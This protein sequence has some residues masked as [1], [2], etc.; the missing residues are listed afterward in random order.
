MVALWTVSVPRPPEFRE[1]VLFGCDQVAQRDDVLVGPDG[2]HPSTGSVDESRAQ[3]L[4][5][6]QPFERCRGGVSEW[7]VQRAR[8]DRRE[9]WAWGGSCSG[10]GLVEMPVMEEMIRS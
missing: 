8:D 4:G 9:Q 1:A 2:V 5:L 10:Q 7:F 6:G 3:V